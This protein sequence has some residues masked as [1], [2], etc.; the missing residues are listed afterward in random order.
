LKHKHAAAGVALYVEENHFPLVVVYGNHDAAVCARMFDA[1][2]LALLGRTDAAVHTVDDGVALARRL[3]HPFTLALAL[4]LGAG[5][6]QFRRD[7]AAVARYAAEATLLCREQSFPLLLA[8]GMAFQGWAEV[9]NGSQQ[10]GAAMI[11]EGI[12]RARRTG[13]DQFLPHLL[14]LAADAQLRI[15]STEDSRCL[16]DEALSIAARTGE[17]FYEAELHRV[18]GEVELAR[19]PKHA[20]EA[21]AA[22]HRA[23]EIARSQGAGLLIL[24]AVVALGRLRQRQGRFREVRPMLEDAVT[25]MAADAALLDV[26]EAAQLLSTGAID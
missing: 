10:D 12:A 24:R 6:H 20:E 16:T 26:R 1:R 3:A 11:A 7:A 9:E 14:C 15:G 22:F 23:V 8:W 18:L 21:A 19:R 2:A 13:S 17:R 4:V 25:H 5:V